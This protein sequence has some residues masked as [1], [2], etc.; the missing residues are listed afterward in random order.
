MH[1]NG[2]GGLP[3]SPREAVTLFHR[4]CDSGMPEACSNLGAKYEYGNGALVKNESRA[5][6]L[7]RR[8]CD[9]GVSAGCSNLG[10][11]HER[12]EVSQRMSISPRLCTVARVMGASLTGARSSR[13]STKV[14]VNSQGTKHRHSRSIGVL[15]SLDGHM[16][17]SLSVLDTRKAQVAYHRT[18]ARPSCF[19]SAGATAVMGSRAG[20]SPASTRK[21]SLDFLRTRNEPG[22]FIVGRVSSTENMVA[23]LEVTDREKRDAD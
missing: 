12:G 20:G 13:I 1:D 23:A 4:A 15:V 17:A 14:E 21:V 19:T 2:T 22:R 3:K 10:R 7:Y 16:G 11:M 9:A 18:T 8:S 6:A 5:A